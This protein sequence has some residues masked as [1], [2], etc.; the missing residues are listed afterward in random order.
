MANVTFPSVVHRSSLRPRI[1]SLHLFISM[2]TL[3]ALPVSYSV[4]MFQNPILETV[5]EKEDLSADFSASYA[6][7]LVD[8][9]DP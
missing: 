1:S 8:T 3:A 5:L 2:V 6:L 9:N 4:R 7:L